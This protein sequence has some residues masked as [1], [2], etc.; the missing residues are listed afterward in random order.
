MMH[1][2]IAAGDWLHE[3]A[4]HPRGPNW[5]AATNVKAPDYTTETLFDNRGRVGFEN[6]RNA[7]IETR[8][9]L[10]DSLDKAD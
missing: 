9:G 6:S 1:P 8:A 4:A 3:K 10:V 5:S 2:M 7:V